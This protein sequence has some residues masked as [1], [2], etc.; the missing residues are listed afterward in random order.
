MAFGLKSNREGQPQAMALNKW[1][2]RAAILLS[3]PVI[4][5]ASFI[6]LTATFSSDMMM[7]VESYEI[8]DGLY[9]VFGWPLTRIVDIF[10]GPGRLQDSDNWW[11]IPMFNVLLLFQ[12]II[13]AQLIVLIGTVLETLWRPFAKPTPSVRPVWPDYL[14]K[15]DGRRYRLRTPLRKRTVPQASLGSTERRRCCT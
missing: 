12:W 2:T 13:W 3:A 9:M 4:L 11:A 1:A 10:A 7:K 6:E 5:F 15:A 8:G 14:V